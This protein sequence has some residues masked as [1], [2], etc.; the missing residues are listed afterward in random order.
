MAKKRYQAGC[1]LLVAV[2]GLSMIGGLYGQRHYTQAVILCN[3]SP[4]PI[5]AQLPKGWAT[6]SERVLSP[7]ECLRIGVF[8]GG[9]EL[10]GVKVRSRSGSRKVIAIRSD[11]TY[12]DLIVRYTNGDKPKTDFKH[13]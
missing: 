13:D 10:I 3:D 6:E 2:C 12:D 9:D 1:L 8:F 5:S 7:G 4:E 11:G